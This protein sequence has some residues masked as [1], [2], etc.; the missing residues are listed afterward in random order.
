MML[1]R[2]SPNAP[3]PPLPGA[4]GLTDMGGRGVIGPDA[5]RP[6]GDFLNP[7]R[8]LPATLLVALAFAGCMG[9][10]AQDSAPSESTTPTYE[11][12]TPITFEPIAN[13]DE[14]AFCWDHDGD[15]KR[16]ADDDANGDG[17]VNRR[18]CW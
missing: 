15:G 10:A 11:T 6:R 9:G 1:L 13:V 17:A 4:D 8:T 18:D 3:G 16:S 5:L 12:Y 7:L 2:G 14:P